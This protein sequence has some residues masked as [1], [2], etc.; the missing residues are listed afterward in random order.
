[1]RS[2]GVRHAPW[3]RLSGMANLHQPTAADAQ[4][5]PKMLTCGRWWI[6][7]RIAHLPA[8]QQ[9]KSIPRLHH[10]SSLWPAVRSPAAGRTGGAEPARTGWIGGVKPHVARQ[11]QPRTNGRRP[12]TNGTD[13]ADRE[14]S[15]VFY[16]SQSHSPEVN[17]EPT[18]NELLTPSAIVVGIDGSRAAIQAA[19]WAVDE[20][21]SRDIPLRRRG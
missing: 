7:H 10:T 11:P 19:L 21:V 1:M 17:P 4:P 12:R 3:T 6:L 16:V 8:N 2:T 20:A 9:P 13:N 5:A 15:S 14:G 18:M